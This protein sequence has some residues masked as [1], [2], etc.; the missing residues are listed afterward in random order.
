VTQ[1]VFLSELEIK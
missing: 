1:N